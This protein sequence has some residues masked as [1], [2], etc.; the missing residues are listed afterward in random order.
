MSMS[1]AFEAR[2]RAAVV[3]RPALESGVRA[4]V[5]ANSVWVTLSMLQAASL[6]RALIYQHAKRLHRSRCAAGGVAR[7][8]VRVRVG[9]RGA[10]VHHGPRDRSAA[11]GNE[12]VLRAVPRRDRRPRGRP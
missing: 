12:A 3:P 10:P 9:I 5:A 4:S 8:R 11:G 7:A 6:L 2:M 1:G